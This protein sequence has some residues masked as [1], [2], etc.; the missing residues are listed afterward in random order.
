M[1][2]LAG[3]LA[4]LLKEENCPYSPTPFSNV[5]SCFYKQS[6]S[7]TCVLQRMGSHLLKYSEEINLFVAVDL[8]ANAWIF[9]CQSKYRM[10][11]DR[12]MDLSVSV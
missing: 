7:I 4:E 10:V 8:L 5:N 12:G 9:F 6:D 11:F 1:E 3:L 2:A